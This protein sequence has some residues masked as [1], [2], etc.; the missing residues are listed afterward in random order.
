MAIFSP[1]EKCCGQQ[2]THRSI[3]SRSVEVDG[4]RA[5]GHWWVLTETIEWQCIVN[6]W[7]RG[8]QWA[9]IDDTPTD[10]VPLADPESS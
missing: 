6:P 4:R 7:H 5:D 3:V 2:P 1:P 9:M 8:G 10:A